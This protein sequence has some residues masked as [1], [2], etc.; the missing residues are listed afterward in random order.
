MTSGCRY[1]PLEAP[2]SATDIPQPPAFFLNEVRE[3]NLQLAN[4]RDAYDQ[5]LRNVTVVL[6]C[7]AHLVYENPLLLPVS[8]GVA[9]QDQN[10]ADPLHKPFIME[11]DGR[12]SVAELTAQFHVA[13]ESNLLQ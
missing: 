12:K 9:T 11:I 1:F 5:S 13:Q 7:P 10:G 8:A 2:A 6:H 4:E 3:L